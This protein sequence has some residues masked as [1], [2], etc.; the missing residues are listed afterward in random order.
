MVTYKK[1]SE[2]K[3][4]IFSIKN[5][6]SSEEALIDQFI[7]SNTIFNTIFLATFFIIFQYLL[8]LFTT[9]FILFK[10]GAS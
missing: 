3:D 10:F 5:I 7:K 2:A 6:F 8:S 1:Y 4:K 9:S